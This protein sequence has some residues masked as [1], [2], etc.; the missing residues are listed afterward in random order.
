MKQGYRVLNNFL[1]PSPHKKNFPSWKKIWGLNVPPK[2]RNFIWRC[3][4]HYLPSLSSMQ[5]RNVEVVNVCYFCQSHHEDNFHV[6]IQC[7]FI[8]QIW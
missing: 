6:L 7:P 5:S 2:V 3:M 8:K 1:H 4:C